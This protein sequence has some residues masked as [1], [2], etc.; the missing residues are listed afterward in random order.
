MNRDSLE[1]YLNDHL[2]GSVTALEMIEHLAKTCADTQLQ[3]FFTDLHIEITADQQVLQDLMKALDLHEGAIRKA[4][5]WV[6][7]K[8]GRAKLG[9]DKDEG[10]GVEF[11]QALEALI[12]GITGKKLLW[13]S[14]A[15]A[16]DDVPQLRSPNYA[17]LEARA[18]AQSDLVE[19]KRLVAARAAFRD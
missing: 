8:I 1:T 3:R 17:D 5:A 18:M 11:L 10:G 19:A 2:A 7:E 16:A 15:A 12:L 9:F 6:I 4:G 14:L 13:R